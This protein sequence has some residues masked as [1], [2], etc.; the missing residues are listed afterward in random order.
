MGISLIGFAGANGEGGG[1]QGLKGLPPE[2]ADGRLN[3]EGGPVGPAP[4]AGLPLTWNSPEAGNIAIGIET[5]P[6][7]VEMDVTNAFSY[8]IIDNPGTLAINGFD[9]TL[10]GTYPQDSSLVS[11]LTAAGTIGTV[12]EFEAISTAVAAITS[13]GGETID[14]YSVVAGSLPWGIIINPDTGAI[15]GTNI[16]IDPS[17]E[18]VESELAGK[19]TWTTASGTLGT[20]NELEAVSTAIAATPVGPAT[21]AKYS[22]LSG[23]LPW[24]VVLNVSTGA[25]T[26]TTST[27]ASNVAGAEFALTPIP[28][29]ITAS[30]SLGS[31]TASDPVNIALSATANLGSTID[32]WSMING[33]LP[34]GALL[35]KATGAITGNISSEAITGLYSF[36]IKIIDDAGSAAVET[37][38]ITI[39]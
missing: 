24:G 39:T 18:V 14:K 7:R 20:H 13:A 25:I 10:Y 8:E 16:G 37:F 5:T 33:F 32:S 6:F 19:P 21:I 2:A 17:N 27:L 38:T 9:G 34:W 36:D 29:W 4:E 31:F 15:T 35:N 1:L 30:G 28:S 26:G 22:I 23:A 11:W 12:D 3:P